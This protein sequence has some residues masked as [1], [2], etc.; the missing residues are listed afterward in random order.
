MFEMSDDPES[1]TQ[2]M[3]RC[4]PRGV[5]ADALLDCLQL[6]SDARKDRY[7]R[8]TRYALLLAL[9][10]FSLEEIP[11][12]R[13]GALLEQL[14]DWHR[15]DPSS[16][17]HSASGWLLRQWGQ[18]E[19]AR[20][21][22]Q[23]AVP[24]ATDREWFTLAITVKPT[25]LTKPEAEPPTE[26]FY[27]TLIVFPE[28]KATIGSVNDEPDPKK[29][30]GRH[31]V[32]LTRPFALLDREITLLELT[33]FSPKYARFMR[34]ND[35][36][37]VDAGFG[38]DWYDAV[39]FCRW[40][41]QQLGLPEGDQ[42]YAAPE[43]LE[44]AKHP[45]EPNPAA[46]WAPRNW[47][48]ELGRRG[49]RLPTETEWEV[50]SRAGARTPYGFGSEVSLLGRFGW[51][52]E[53]SGKRVHPP[54]ELRPSVRGLFDLHGNLFEWTHDWFGDYGGD[55]M[56][57]P[58]GARDGSSRVLRGGNW[59]D[60]PALCRSAYRLALD[61]SSRSNARGFR[62]A[63]SLSGVT[64]QGASVTGTEPSRKGAE[65]ACEPVQNGSDSRLLAVAADRPKRE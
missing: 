56:T 32:T 5:A 15:H 57:D 4:R 33:A 37:P 51:F 28:G 9:G 31:C 40:L 1:L 64:P 8:N 44:Q 61:P 20:R 34:Q 63:L 29:N 65:D 50:A 26:T 14:A 13:R 11:E 23:T 41:G 24:Y 55:A 27:Y 6:V 36:Q 39:G 22:D 2:F 48:L 62:L 42:S 16:G 19:V 18:A 58:L 38:P 25:A 3:V 12:S 59:G 10:E 7:P 60:A 47:P 17:V 35:A 54:R 53:N 52:A 45:R 46:N 43:T 21:V 49:F 30:E